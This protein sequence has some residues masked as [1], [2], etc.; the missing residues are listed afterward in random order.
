MTAAFSVLEADERRSAAALLGS[1]DQSNQWFLEK[2]LDE[3]DGDV[4]LDCTSVESLDDD[5]VAAL[6]RFRDRAARQRRRVTFRSLPSRYWAALR[7]R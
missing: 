2:H 1:F 3:L 5:A 7:S 4:L 6:R